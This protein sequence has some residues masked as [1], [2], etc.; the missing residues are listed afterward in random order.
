MTKEDSDFFIMM[1]EMYFIYIP[2]IVLFLYLYKL[3]IETREMIIDLRKD[4]GKL[5]EI[6]KNI[7]K[8]K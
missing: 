8:G 6:I 4:H 5:I 1:F 7:T 2:M 3:I